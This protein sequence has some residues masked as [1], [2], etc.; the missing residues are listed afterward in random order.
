MSGIVIAC[1]DVALILH[2]T[3]YNHRPMDALPLALPIEALLVITGRMRVLKSD[4][5]G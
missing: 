5:H 4:T 1:V 2:L 3:L